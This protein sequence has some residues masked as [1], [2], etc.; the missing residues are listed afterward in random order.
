MGT[1]V[2]TGR[3]TPWDNDVYLSEEKKEERYA[4]PSNYKEDKKG[5]RDG[6][7]NNNSV[8][9]IYTFLQSLAQVRGS[10]NICSG[11]LVF[12]TIQTHSIM[13]CSCPTLRTF[14]SHSTP[15]L[16]WL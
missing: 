1:R 9:N 5:S 3:V 10:G 16:W 7:S 6:D 2:G 15:L 12:D 11:V 4:P 13:P 14:K 8:Y